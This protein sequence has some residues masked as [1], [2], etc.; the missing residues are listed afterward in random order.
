MCISPETSK[1]HYSILGAVFLQIST[2]TP[3]DKYVITRLTI[4]IL[5]VNPFN[6]YDS[7]IINNSF[8]VL[9]MFQE[10]KKRH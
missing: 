5:I 7:I 2:F 10:K 3:G 1:V 4:I 9:D 8:S 6:R